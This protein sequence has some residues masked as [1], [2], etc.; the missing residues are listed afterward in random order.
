[1]S[2]QNYNLEEAAAALRC[3]VG[4]LEENLDTLPHQKLG[5]A[6]AFDDDELMAIKNMCRVRPGSAAVETAKPPGLSLATIQPKQ[7]RR[8][9]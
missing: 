8:S 7:R 9:G 1:M 4:F 2:L 3:A 6:V 5:R